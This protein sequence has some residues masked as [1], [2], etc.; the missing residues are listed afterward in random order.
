MVVLKHEAKE[1]QAPSCSV[2]SVDADLPTPGWCSGIQFSLNL[3]A[4]A[5]SP[6]LF[7]SGLS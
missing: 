1:A 2:C 4:L 7:T 6:P 3:P 5:S